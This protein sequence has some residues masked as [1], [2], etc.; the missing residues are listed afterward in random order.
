MHSATNVPQNTIIALIRK[1]GAK[2]FKANRTRGKAVTTVEDTIQ[3]LRE[4]VEKVGG[5][6]IAVVVSSND[7]YHYT[8]ILTKNEMERVQNAVNKALGIGEEVKP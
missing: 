7:E 3:L 8:V 1:R 2:Q 5:Y 6:G 4:A